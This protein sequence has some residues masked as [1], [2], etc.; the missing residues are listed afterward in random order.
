MGRLADHKGRKEAEAIYLSF[1]GAHERPQIQI[2]QAVSYLG[3]E[4]ASGT[5]K[6]VQLLPSEGD[7]FQYRIRNPNEPHERV[8][9][10]SDLERIVIVTFPSRAMSKTMKFNYSAPAELFVAK[11]KAGRAPGS[12]IVASQQQQRRSALPSR[13]SA[14]QTGRRLDAGWR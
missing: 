10:E 5:Y 11:Q 14:N 12:N 8:A 13:A 4:R 6:V 3:R 9:K 7:D 2:G 1:G